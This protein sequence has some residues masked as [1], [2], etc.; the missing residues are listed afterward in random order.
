MCTKYFYEYHALAS[1]QLLVLFDEAEP[2][3]S[4]Y[5]FFFLL[6]IFNKYTQKDGKNLKE[7]VNSKI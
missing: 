1:G 2:S 3:I 4:F 5:V 7:T 6:N